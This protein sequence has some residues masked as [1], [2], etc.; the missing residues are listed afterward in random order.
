M[1]KSLRLESKTNT[2]VITYTFWQCKVQD[3]HAKAF[4]LHIFPHCGT[5]NVAK[6]NLKKSLVCPETVYARE[7]MVYHK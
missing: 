6:K 7:A 3:F 2:L 1:N 5:V 4:F